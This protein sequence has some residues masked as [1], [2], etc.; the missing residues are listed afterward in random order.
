MKSLDFLHKACNKSTKEIK[1]EKIQETK[2]IS[3]YDSDA[4]ADNEVYH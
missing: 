1:H 3:F 4:A 2:I